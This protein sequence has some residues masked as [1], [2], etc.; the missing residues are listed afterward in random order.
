MNPHAHH[1][2][3]PGCQNLYRCVCNNRRDLWG[4]TVCEACR[5]QPTMAAAEKKAKEAA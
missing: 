4:P 5:R 1:C 2:R 3:I